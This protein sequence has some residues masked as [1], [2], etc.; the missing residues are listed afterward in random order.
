M[1]TMNASRKS[2][3]DKA[4]K[5]ESGK[6]SKGFECLVHKIESENND[7]TRP[8]YDYDFV[9]VGSGYGGAIAAERLSACKESGKDLKICLLER[10]NEYLP[11]SFPSGF[12]EAAG[13]VRATT[14]GQD[15]VIG[16]SD[17]LFDFR[18]NPDMSAVV[19]SGIG[20]GSLINAGVM[21]APDPGVFD[22]RWPGELQGFSDP[23]KSKFKYFKKARKL[24]GATQTIKDHGKLP[25]KYTAH[26]KLAA[27]GKCGEF[28]AARITVAM[29]DRKTKS[30]LRLDKCI[31]CGDCVTGCNFG[32]KESLD[33]NLLD[34]A[35]FRGVKLY[36]GAT[37][38]RIERIDPSDDL[39]GRLGWR[40]VVNY[41]HKQLRRR[42]RKPV[43]VVA[44]RVILAAGTFGS[45]EILKRSET[46]SLTFSPMLGRKF[47][48]NG[49]MIAS[50]YAQTGKVESVARYDVAPAKRSVGP[51]I[52]GIIEVDR[53]Q[54]KRPFIVEELA[55]PNT[56]HHFYE[57]LVTTAQ[58]LREISRSDCGRHRDGAVS[59]DPFAVDRDA[60][61]RTA[62]MA[63]LGDD[64]A[65]GELDFGDAAMSDR[66]VGCLN[67][68]WPDAKRASVFDEQVQV[69]K[70]ICEESGL[71]GSVI[72]N[73]FWQFLPGEIDFLAE[74]NLR[75]PLLT[76]HP[77]GGCPMGE[78]VVT[79]VVDHIGQVFDDRDPDGGIYEGLVVLDGSIVP[80][81]LEINPALTISALSLRAMDT[82]I[83]KVW[84]LDQEFTFPTDRRRSIYREIPIDEAPRVQPTAVRLLERMG[85]EVSLAGAGRNKK[86]YV[87]ITLRST[88]CDLR[89]LI[90]AGCKTWTIDVDES[91]PE[92]DS[93]IRVFE[94][95]EWERLHDR[96]LK[97][98]DDSGDLVGGETELDDHEFEAALNNSAVFE[99]PLSG[100]IELF[101]R[102]PTTACQRRRRAIKAWFCNRGARE[103]WQWLA[104]K[105][106]RLVGF[107]LPQCRKDD[108]A[109]PANSGGSARGFFKMAEELW[110][111]SS[112]AGEVRTLEYVLK[113]RKPQKPNNPKEG[114]EFLGAFFAPETE[115]HGV[116]YLTYCRRANPWRQL[117][118]LQLEKFPGSGKPPT[119]ALDLKYLARQGVP[120]FRIERQQD[121][122]TAITDFAALLAYVLR[123][124]VFVHVWS[125]REPDAPS[126]KKPERYPGPLPD[127]DPVIHEISSGDE[128]DGEPAGFRLTHY[129][130]PGMPPVIAI[131]GYS[132]SG[133]MFAHPRIKKNA[134][135]FFHKKK[136]DVWIL[137]LRTSGASRTALHSWTF[138]DVAFRDIPLAFRYVHAETGKKI[139]VLAH[140]MGA[141]MLSMAIL[142]EPKPPDR[143]YPGDR[144]YK[145]RKDLPETINCIAMSQVGP[146]IYFSP[147]N[148]FRAYLANYLL[149][150]LPKSTYK[151]QPDGDLSLL[152]R[153]IDRVLST[154][155]YPDE[156][157][158]RENPPWYR[159]CK[160]TPFT[161]TRH[162]ADFLYGRDFSIKNVNDGL[163]EHIDDIFG[164]LNI[165]TIAQTI[166]FARWKT[167]TTVAGNNDFVS[168]A[169]LR[170]RWKSKKSSINTLSVHGYEND[171]ADV[172]TVELNRRLFRD[173]GINFKK[174]VYPDMGHMDCIIGDRA[175]DVF[176]DIAKFFA[177]NSEDL[178]KQRK[179]PRQN[180]RVWAAPPSVGPLVGTRVELSDRYENTYQP[181]KIGSSPGMIAT[182]LI[183]VVPV[184]H[185][186]GHFV[187][188]D[189][190]KKRVFFVHNGSRELQRFAIRMQ[191]RVPEADGAAM[192][193]IHT[194]HPGLDNELFDDEPFKI[195]KFSLSKNVLNQLR[196]DL[197]VDDRARGGIDLIDELVV[198]LKDE[199]DD[200]IKEWLRKPDTEV[201]TSVIKFV[202]DPE[203]VSSEQD[204]SRLQL[205]FALASCQYPPGIFDRIPAYESY[206]RLADR[207]D[208]SNDLS[209]LLLIG[210]Q[211][212]VDSTA[213]LFDIVRRDD[214]Y[215]RPYQLLYSN[216]HVRRVLRRL[217]SF[218]MLD[219]HEIDNNW[220]PIPGDSENRTLLKDGC[221][222]FLNWQEKYDWIKPEYKVG[223]P[224]W[225]RFKYGGANGIP[226]FV[227]DSRT[228]REV[229][230]ASDYGGANIIRENQFKQLKDWLIQYKNQLKFIVSPAI[231]F[232]RS[233]PLTLN[234][235]TPEVLRSDRWD[236]YPASHEA[237]VSY[238]F[239]NEIRNVV[240]LSGD[241]HLSMVSEV[242]IKQSGSQTAGDS[243]STDALRL[244]SIHSSGLYAP[245]P[246][247]NSREEDF[248][249]NETYEIERNGS[250]FHVNVETKPEWIYPGDGFAIVHVRKASEA[251]EI[252]VEFS[253]AGEGESPG[254]Y[255][256][257]SDPVS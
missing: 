79:G 7:N 173:A 26:K 97:D 72:P 253:R 13:Y 190:G 180:P 239:D 162:R 154:L 166:H 64:G 151:L 153:L 215:R 73:P 219:D 182:G 6:L 206:C 18:I 181:V 84:H 149:P 234:P 29:N 177:E 187:E 231:P 56:L 243:K 28:R 209:F 203:E 33:T 131:H 148:I 199:I 230:N 95:E 144:F 14:P 169:T 197:G 179:T 124:L 242:T 217:P 5:K 246:F 27:K 226:F 41:T 129:P 128:P 40:L 143:D 44:R 195:Q 113:V 43:E 101:N 19:A 168:L 188:V 212:Y 232:P 225:Y 152:D 110:A 249:L 112:R 251:W 121:Q 141:A 208:E 171:L 49:D 256:W 200:A 202:S 62:V 47:S 51:S 191:D 100:H 32:A 160:K 186:N 211:V 257:K 117:M 85:G 125:F 237:L 114:F 92:T 91:E 147:G 165:R 210:D 192:L 224:L 164:H 205:D 255:T 159:A 3:D 107:V 228:D 21:E 134:V 175:S 196:D 122:P 136:Y 103:I 227:L 126:R 204:D 34:L 93:R 138:E 105:S 185:V 220:E 99:A 69:L 229:R 109:A 63:I 207:L 236:G 96:F 119:L 244:L 66:E 139:N 222:E 31:Q 150:I 247:A 193:Y 252:E 102:R 30:K 146:R 9:I 35:S 248:E 38:E 174:K 250:N 86:Y 106:R 123:Y 221:R 233:H 83:D 241:E 89:G 157:F 116:K 2:K 60:I 108:S 42:Q 52:T 88:P 118:E 58:S 36:H 37:V 81:A 90:A 145:A 176:S 111:L 178:A 115:L 65:R 22:S 240:F 76:V 238:L 1:I 61:D 120:L 170:K 133:S 156:E 245:F 75:G 78:D 183:A 15:E 23:D 45:T 132:I 48:G 235:S 80:T 223:D 50:A 104:Q 98:K 155:P 161:R 87:D 67:V 46:D 82:L 53:G 127:L 137:D 254:P 24:L 216:R 8:P 71:E 140:C 12:S 214:K 163:L 54:D 158:D 74:S 198:E 68:N 77:L 172:A 59:P 189:P 55:I 184:E 135:E 4:N 57:E 10:G 130:N 142:R 20:G 201:E 39:Q 94:L 213:G 17:G 11:G 167:I 25:K 218:N 70:R 16:V 194:D